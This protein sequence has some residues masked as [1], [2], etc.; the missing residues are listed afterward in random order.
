MKKSV[1]SV[2]GNS[3][4]QIKAEIHLFKDSQVLGNHIVE[5]THSEELRVHITFVIGKNEFYHKN[6]ISEYNN[7]WFHFYFCSN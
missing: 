7:H 1:V 6:K 3:A 2:I 5:N 4:A